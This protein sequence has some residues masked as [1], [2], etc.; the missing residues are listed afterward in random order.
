MALRMLVGVACAVA[1]AARAPS[2]RLVESQALPSNMFDAVVNGLV[3]HFLR[4]GQGASRPLPE[5][6]AQIPYAADGGNKYITIKMSGE[7]KNFQQIRRSGVA[8]LNAD[9]NT[10]SG[11]ISIDNAEVVAQ[12]TGSF[13]AVGVAPA[14]TAAGTTSMKGQVFCDLTMFVDQDGKPVSITSARGRVGWHKYGGATGLNGNQYGPTYEA[15]FQDSLRIQ[16][17]DM[18]EKTMNLIAKNQ[19]LPK[20]GVE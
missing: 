19:V 13:P 6:T 7:L 8:K 4:T 20:I 18:C 1:V 11:T 9:S 3:H 12:Y 14:N 17:K 15:A 16:L 5:K 10:L 2:A